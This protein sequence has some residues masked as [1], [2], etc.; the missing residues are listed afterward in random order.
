MKQLDDSWLTDGWVDFEYKKYL[1]LAYLQHVRSSFE[2]VELYPTLGDLVRHYSNLQKFVETRD[3]LQENFPE[4][5]EGIDS[6]RF[7]LQFKKVLEDDEVMEAIE[8]IIRFALPRMKGYLQEGSELYEFVEEQC[9]LAPIGVIPLYDQEGYF[10]VSGHSRSDVLIHQ[11]QIT[12]IQHYNEEMRGI[13]STYVDT[14]TKGAGDT[15]E[16]IKRNLVL[17]NKSMPNPATFLI[18]SKMAFPDEP[19]LIPVAK[20][21]LVRYVYKRN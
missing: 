6:K 11:Y 9:E 19:T 14:V 1:L 20:R 3:Q 13:H 4:T 15:Y 17:K 8:K 12:V 21:M 2:K 16:G 5:L 10:F 7:R 18:H